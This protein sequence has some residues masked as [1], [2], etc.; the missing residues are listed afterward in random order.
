MPDGWHLCPNDHS[1]RGGKMQSKNK[2]LELWKQRHQAY[3]K[4]GLG[5]KAFCQKNKLKIS[6]LDYWFSRIR[7]AE[8]HHGL[9]EVKPG[10]IPSGNNC[11]TLVVA[12]RYR[13]E[14]KNGFD[15][16]L[17]GEVVK[18]LESLG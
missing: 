9:V 4:S 15:A 14:V 11:L 18:A 1:K 2:K 10:S 13:I 7:S 5:R 6:T 8:K 16:Q 12:D 3:Q 17:F